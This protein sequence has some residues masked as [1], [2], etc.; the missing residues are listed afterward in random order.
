MKWII[1]ILIVLSLIPIA[2]AAYDICGD[3]PEIKT[4]CQMITPSNL[5]CTNYTYSIYNINTTVV[6]NGLLTP[7]SSNVYYFNFTQGVGHY[8][9]GLCDGGIR[10]VFVNEDFNSGYYLYVVA[11]ILFIFLIVL[12]KRCMRC[13][14]RQA[15]GDACPCQY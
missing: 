7:L 6:T 1:I 5:Q 11:T 4:N 14:R 8:Y 12:E 9:V 2:N 15:L 3:L 13:G 10:E